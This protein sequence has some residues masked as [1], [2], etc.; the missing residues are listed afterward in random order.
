MAPGA[1]PLPP[2]PALQGATRLEARRLTGVTDRETVAEGEVRLSRDDASVS[3]ERI[4]YL[5]A[6]D[7]V[8]A[9]GDV[10]LTKNLDVVRGPEL[11]L[12]LADHVGH[13]DHPRYAVRRSP[14]GAAGG[15]PVTA[16]GAADRIEFAGEDHY[17]LANASYSTC[18][19]DKPDWHLAVRDL[20]LD[21][22]RETGTARGAKVVFRDVPLF[23]APWMDFALNDRRKSGILAP[24]LGN[25][26]RTGIDLSLPFYWNIAPNRD[27]TIAPRIM[28]R[29]GAML[30]GEF[31]YL[32]PAYAGATQIEWLGKD[33]VLDR[34]R[35]LLTWQHTQSLAPGL[36]GAINVSRVS[37]DT[38]FSDL[39]TRI[40][41]TSQRNLL[42]QGGLTYNGEW[43][44]GA[45]TVQRYQ[46]L[47]DA[48][49]PRIDIPYDRLPWI[50]FSAWGSGP[51]RAALTLNSELVNFSHPDL[52]QGRRVVLYPQVSLPLGGS[53]AYLTPRIG[54]N[55]SRYQLTNQP[56]G[57]PDGLT[58][59]LP[60]ASIDSG[61]NFEREIAWGGSTLTHTLEPRL[62]YLYVPF[63]DQSLYPVFDT[64]AADFNFAQIFSENAFVGR[65][66]IA[67]ANQVTAALS[68]R[69][70]DPAD[71][72]ELV[73]AM[74]GQR[75]YFSTP[76]VTLPGVAPPSRRSSDL[77][78]AV[79]GHLT[80]ALSVETA[81]QYNP[82]ENR[83]ERFN[84]SG[85]YQPEFGRVLNAG[86]RY[87]S[88][89]VREIDA[90]A[91]W[92]LSGRWYGVGRYNYS[93]QDNR[94]V[95]AIAGL[96]Y[97]GGCWILRTVLHRFATATQTANTAFFVQ[98]ELN[99]L[100]RI[101]SNPLELLKRSIGGYGQI[102]QP[103]ADPA[104]GTR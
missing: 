21:F 38:Y 96:E 12:R 52:T 101:G 37:D 32:E 46:T 55:F 88:G 34:S 69:L 18:T 47:Q 71:G 99:G 42:R 89:V 3:A 63:R 85:R 54:L 93:F 48:S 104:F 19:G 74:I 65:D 49:L 44:N 100:S 20:E 67:D 41:A 80:R 17:R 2:E 82:K 97:D 66:R 59:T 8:E 91:Q 58:R 1:Q 23:Y 7:T 22:E 81:L 86:Y 45:F 84:L 98:L 92:P 51:R 13:F 40:S 56:A 57:T 36:S 53:A 27:A 79:S 14:R 35:S 90:S 102:N 25:S 24:T 11:R 60:I 26:T 43:W 28:S 33:N 64:A 76:T 39:S 87:Q 10:T 50:T 29:R 75:L 9:S 62:F 95:E 78:A 70:I 94:L 15:A 68:S 103:I 72:A 30:G 16:S 83:P 4:R 5:H 31:R 6:E 73:R 77:L 61:L